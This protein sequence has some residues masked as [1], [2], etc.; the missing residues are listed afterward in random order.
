LT[1]PGAWGGKCVDHFGFGFVLVVFGFGFGTVILLQLKRC[2]IIVTT[3][4]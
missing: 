2:G 1:G 4:L 3:G